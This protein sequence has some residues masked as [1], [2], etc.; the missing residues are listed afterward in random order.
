MKTRRHHN[1]HALTSTK[2]GKRKKEVHRIAKG[3]MGAECPRCD[4]I[5]DHQG[6]WIEHRC[7]ICG[8]K[9][10]TCRPWPRRVKQD[11]IMQRPEEEPGYG[12]G[13]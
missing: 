11:V 2:R 7:N 1:N 9:L 8:G 3:V 5:H 4:G 12:H 13:V 6:D 10:V